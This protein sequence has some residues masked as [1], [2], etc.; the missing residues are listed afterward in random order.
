MLNFLWGVNR[1]V[2]RSFVWMFAALSMV[3]L[4][5]QPGSIQNEWSHAAGVWCGQG[6]RDVL[7]PEIQTSKDGTELALTNIA[8][9][10]CWPRET[11]PRLCPESR[12][13]LNPISI[14]GGSY[15]SLFNFGLS[16]LVLPSVDLSVLLIRLSNAFILSA[17]LAVLSLLLP[18][19]YQRTLAL[20]I[21]AVFTGPGLFMMVSI[22]P[23]SW[24]TIGIGL[25]WLPLHAALAP[26]ELG[27]A[28]RRTLAAVSVLL[29]VLAVGSQRSAIGFSVV[30]LALIAAH[31][32]WLAL[33]SRRSALFK[34]FG[35]SLGVLLVALELLS[36]RTPHTLF[37]SSFSPNGSALNEAAPESF[38]YLRDLLPVIPSAVRALFG[39]PSWNPANPLLLTVSFP[40]IVTL[41]GVGLLGYLIVRSGCS[42]QGFQAVG[43]GVVLSVVALVLFAQVSL[44]E[45]IGN[46]VPDSLSVY[47]LIAF[48]AGWWFFHAPFERSECLVNSLRTPAVIAVALFAVTSFTVAER[49][50]DRQTFGL[51]YL[52][53]G[54]DQWWWTAMPVGPNVI[55][56]LASMFLWRFLS[57]YTTA[58][59]SSENGLRRT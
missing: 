3:A 34:I 15:P 10:E 56:I 27:T 38:Y 21:V 8:D 45:T 14:T 58:L 29:F 19:Q 32:G 50:V 23:L 43:A 59:V 47:P 17:T 22:N 52:P 46:T 54:L 40:E 7:C 39:F 5:S 9:T 6:E 41:G 18:R 49:F 30:V 51:R 57:A 11:A 28:H 31:L 2:V 26:N 55:L 37:L 53:E 12:T 48:L 16:W 35:I 13:D 1:P 20:L 36:P 4:L 25:G 44:Q 42:K 24:A 33:P